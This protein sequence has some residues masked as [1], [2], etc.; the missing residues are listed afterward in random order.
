[1]RPDLYVSMRRSGIDPASLKE[2]H[3]IILTTDGTVTDILEAYYR[4]RMDVVPVRQ[5]TVAANTLTPDH[6]R[7]LRTDAG[8]VLEREIMLRGEISESCHIYAH[9]FIALDRLPEPVL[10]GLLERKKPIGHLLFEH[11]VAT[12]KEIIDCHR[13]P[14]AA[15][16][17]L[18]AISDRAPMLSR[19]YVLSIED[20]P[21]MLITEKFPEY[22]R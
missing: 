19:T 18:F 13:E 16:A 22:G 4:E 10:A 1:M 12:F 15:L 14:A 11:R 8:D 9:S 5:V 7:A 21:M 3:R 6:Q 2:L 17:K 20:K